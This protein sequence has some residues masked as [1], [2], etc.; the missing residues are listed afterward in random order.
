MT[1]KEVRDLVTNISAWGGNAF[2]LAM[3]VA[4][5]QRQDDATIAETLGQAEVA[6]SIRA[7]S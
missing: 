2:T 6:E 1:A 7:A 3:R 4:E 5:Q